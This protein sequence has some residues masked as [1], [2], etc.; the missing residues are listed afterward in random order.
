MKTVLLL[1]LI[2]GALALSDQEATAG[3]C[4]IKV[5]LLRKSGESTERVFVQHTRNKQECE[6]TASLHRMNYAPQTVAK[7]TVTAKFKEGR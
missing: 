5:V 4:E 2:R 3:N 7:V 1:I 6:K